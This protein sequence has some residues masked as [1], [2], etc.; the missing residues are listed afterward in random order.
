MLFIVALRSLCK[1][2]DERLFLEEP[3][4]VFAK[5]VDLTDT[6]LDFTG[7]YLAAFREGLPEDESKAVLQDRLDTG[8]LAW[9]TRMEV[10]RLPGWDEQAWTADP[11]CQ[12]AVQIFEETISAPGWWQEVSGMTL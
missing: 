5:E 4:D 12:P 3:L 9:G 8:W 7:R 11:A 6:S 2:S 10:T 1:E